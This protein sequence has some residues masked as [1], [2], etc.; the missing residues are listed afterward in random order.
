MT[1]SA[2]RRWAFSWRLSLFFGAQ[3]F[4]YGVHLPFFPVW[5]DWRGM[6]AAEIGIVA[7][8][9]MFLRIFVGPAAAFLAD[10]SGDH[11]RAVIIA[12]ACTLMAALVLIQSY[13]FL[14]IL[15]LTAIYLVG[16]QTAGPISEAVALAGVRDHGADYGRMR[17]WGSLSF[18]VATLFGGVMLGHFG[19]V[20]IGWLVVASAGLMLLAAWL[21]PVAT[22]R[23]ELDEARKPI[24]LAEVCKVAG[25]GNFLLF[26]AAAGT[27]QAS[28]ALFYAFGVLHWQ[29]LGISTELISILWSISIIA[30]VA[31]FAYAGKFVKLL[32][33]M[34]LILAGGVA[35]VVR[36]GSMACDPPIAV[37]FVLQV[38]HALTFA[39]THLGSMHF[40]Q[41]A[42]PREQAGTAQAI[43][44]AATGGL[45]T[46]GA[47]LLAGFLYGPYAGASYLAMMAIAS[48]GV[49]AGLV[50][51]R[52]W[53]M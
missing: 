35:A 12:S 21:L 13:A 49:I 22:A 3:F 53:R 29:S 50:L 14:V 17:L 2:H 36:W 16:A 52:R 31:L 4:L 32:G 10:R 34:G 20:A 24:T 6:S 40:I 25:S 51:N 26:V 28:H 38:L 27:V 47:M 8:A 46:S 11:R 30:E 15:A 37:L 43:Y 44:A 48:V 45:I 33:P 39:A 9:P 41:R 42:V 1:S 7:A 5:L 19:A 23:T 18:I